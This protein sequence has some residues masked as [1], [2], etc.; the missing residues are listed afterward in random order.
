MGESRRERIQ[1]LILHIKKVSNVIEL[2][3][4][5]NNLNIVCYFCH[6][7]SR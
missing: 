7:G 5:S 2:R 3:H 1:T 4:L 6:S